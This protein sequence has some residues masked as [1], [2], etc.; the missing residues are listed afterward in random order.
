MWV[1]IAYLDWGGA[2]GESRKNQWVDRETKQGQK[3]ILGA[4]VHHCEL[5]LNPTEDIRERVQDTHSWELSHLKGEDWGLH[6]YAVTSQYPS[7]P[8][9]GLS[10]V[11]IVDIRDVSSQKQSGHGGWGGPGD[12]S[13]PQE[14]C[15][16]LLGLSVCTMI[17][18]SW[19]GPPP[20]P[21]YRNGEERQP[22]KWL[23]LV[24]LLSM[25]SNL[26]IGLVVLLVLTYAS[27]I[28]NTVN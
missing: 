10:L 4:L 19:P 17:T 18:E 6:P 25:I 7:L 23:H 9:D 20:T 16:C 1:P 11:P 3:P 15:Y 5:E 28:I 2:R 14:L 27:T 13:G 22:F 12:M 26:K 8:F 24:I 21:S